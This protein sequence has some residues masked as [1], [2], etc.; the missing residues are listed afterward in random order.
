[1]EDV[2]RK[3]CAVSQSGFAGVAKYVYAASSAP[4]G[5]VSSAVAKYVYAPSSATSVEPVVSSFAGNPGYSATAS[6]PVSP[7]VSAVF[8]AGRIASGRCQSPV[9][10]ADTYIDPR[11]SADF[12]L[13]PVITAVVASTSA[14]SRPARASA[15]FKIQ[16]SISAVATHV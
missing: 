15:V 16:P 4:V 10:D 7:A 5:P 6:L 1:M 3:F 2:L 9:F 13:L 8:Q 11:W 14:G 12:F